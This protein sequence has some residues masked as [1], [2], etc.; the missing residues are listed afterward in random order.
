MSRVV[1]ITGGASGIGLTL[2]RRFAALGDR[3]AI[4][5]RDG[6]ALA[7]LAGEFQGA[8]LVELDVGNEA[9]VE[10][11]FAKVETIFGCP[12][13]VLSNA[14]TGGP[15]GGIETLDYKD[16]S[17]CIGVNLD[18]AFLVCRAAAHLMRPEGRG[19]IL[20]TS[21]TSGLWGVPNRSPYVAAKWGVI[22]LMKTLAM[23]LGPHGI[24]V[25]ALCPGAVEGPRME[26]VIAMESLASGQSPD[27]I[28]ET[29]AQGVSLRRFVTADDVADMAIF[30]A[31]DAARSVSGQAVSIDGHTERMV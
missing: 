22:G 24:R 31:S 12:D 18:G 27:H 20:I 16:W 25:N 1:L 15:A 7:A 13:V 3:V 26:R 28:R 6:A 23:E 8:V 11:F 10:A 19:V 17:D 21:S 14:G 9:S 5:D 29:Y 4:G 30:L 2:A